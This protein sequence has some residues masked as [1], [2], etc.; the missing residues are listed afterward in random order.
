M[1][2]NIL[3][4]KLQPPSLSYEIYDSNPDFLLTETNDTNK[5]RKP[6][7]WIYYKYYHK[8]KQSVSNS[9]RK[10]RE[11][12]ERKEKFYPQSKSSVSFS[13]TLRLV[14][15]NIIQKKNLGPSCKRLFT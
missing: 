4:S 13:N 6:H 8:S 3:T 10:P 12:D 14:K 1:K 15:T 2:I 7:F 11:D 9:F 5:Q